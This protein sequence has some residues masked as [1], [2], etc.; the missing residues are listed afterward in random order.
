MGLLSF[1][2]TSCLA[3]AEPSAPIRKFYYS[4]DGTIGGNS[5]RWEVTRE[6]D[7]SVRFKLSDYEERGYEDLSDTVP[8]TFMDSLEALCR[9]HKV[10]NWDGFRGINRHVCDGSGFTLDIDYEDG[11][12]VSA[13]GMNKFPSGYRDFR[14]ELYELCKPVKAHLKELG[15]QR[16]IAQGVQGNLRSVMVIYILRNGSSNYEYHAL[17]RAEDIT[18]NNVEVRIKNSDGSFFP[19]GDWNYYG[20]VTDSQIGMQEFAALIKK[21]HLIQWCDFD[22]HADVPNE[23]EWFQIA[24]HFDQGEIHACGTAH[25]EHYDAF[26]RDLLRLLASKCKQWGVFAD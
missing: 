21:H 6:Q 10:H 25:P 15:R 14:E 17:L 1:L 20:H 26:R 2:Q 7:G 24:F 8:A 19:K 3:K 22:A 16:K 13:H 18:E 12:E 9:R 23:S 11:R 4:Y 5:F